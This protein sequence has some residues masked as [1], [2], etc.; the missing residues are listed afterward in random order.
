MTQRLILFDID[1]T[2]LMSN[3]IGREAKRRAMLEHFG[4]VGDIENHVFGGKTDWQILV[5]LLE[6]SGKT[7]D[8][9]GQDMPAYQKVMS[10]HMEAIS[11]DFE[12]DVIP[13]AM[14]LVEALRD[15]EDTILGLVT[16][17]M[18]DTA[19]IKLKLAGFDPAW[20]K[21]GAFGNESANRNDL[22]RLAVERA[23][24]LDEKPFTG[25]AVIVVG[26]T[27]ADIHAARAVSAVS[28]AVTTGYVHRDKLICS[29]PDFLLA[30]LS[31]FIDLVMV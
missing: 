9:I 15:R 6:P 30:D 28:V 26:D 31:T 3:G 16:G 4:E 17:N 1:G 12:M 5:D 13:Y 8:D 11:S 29:D 2:L 10:R 14:E 19:C 22:S 21:V 24:N 27:E 18:E 25:D 20:F 23:R 7:I